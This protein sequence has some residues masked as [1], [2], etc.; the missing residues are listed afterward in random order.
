MKIKHIKATFLLA[1]GL[2]LLTPQGLA[3]IISGR[4]SVANDK[5]VANVAVSDGT[6]VVVTDKNG[7]YRIDAEDSANFV[8]IAVPKEGLVCRRRTCLRQKNREWKIDFEER[9][10]S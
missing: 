6:D 3:I 7:M 4:V 8:F 2:L 1:L 9:E 5:A 10:K